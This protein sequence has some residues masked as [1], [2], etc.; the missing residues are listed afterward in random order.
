MR[1]GLLTGL[2]I[3][4]L[5]ISMGNGQRNSAARGGDIAEGAVV[6]DANGVLILNIT[7]CK[8]TP[9]SDYLRFHSPYRRRDLG[10]AS[11]PNGS[12]YSKVSVEQQ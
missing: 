2:L 6:S 1:T 5:L 9:D 8:A 12:R 10:Q 3:T 11:C 4:I 7:P